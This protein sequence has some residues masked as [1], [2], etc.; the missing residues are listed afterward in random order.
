M[1]IVDHDKITSE[2]FPDGATYRTIVSGEDGSSPVLIGIQVS[3]PGYATPTHAHPYVEIITVLEGEAE[4]WSED[5]EETAMLR[6]GMTLVVP[7]KLRH[8]F[9][10]VG[11]KP[12]KTYGVHSSPERI[13]EVFDD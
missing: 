13:V 8:G 10:V 3:P 12:L 7:P 11:E 4:A 2:E 6:S 5:S 1:K 9:R